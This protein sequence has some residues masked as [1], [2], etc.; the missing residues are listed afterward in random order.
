MSKEDTAVLLISH[1]STRP[2]GKVVFDEIKEKF[3]EKTGLKT[4]VG[5]M[6][7]SEPSVAGAVN[8][9]A[10]DENI[11]HIIGL[12]VFLA[13]GIHTRIDIPIMLELE[14]LEVD[15]R[16][17]DGNYP[18]DHYL[19]GL[20]DINFSGELDL[21]DAIGP[22]PRLLEIIKNRIE[23][24]LEESELDEDAKTGVMIVSHGSRLGYN[25]EF[26][27]DLF[28]QFEAQCDYPSSFGFM[29]L[30]T[31]DIPS[32]TNKLTE[33]NE[34]D[35][36]VVVPVFIAPGKHTTHDIPIILRLMEEEHHHHEHDHDHS[37][38]HEHSH[39]HDHEHSHG[40][41]HDHS[42]DLTPIDFEGEVLYPEPICADD[43]LIE[44]LESMI[45]DYL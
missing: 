32:A 6:K 1:G 44:I 5:Y 9:L 18:E 28:T 30:E 31:P 2:Y 24:A 34:I 40:H 38:D 4:E 29:E 14:P 25:K 27:T 36:L 41:H 22:N 42:H 7:V 21:L 3:I 13:P 23:T 35:R 45:Q 16:Q 15:P 33:E 26:L 20:D 11:K 43:V 39:G 12:P 19:C 10:E 17:P 8:I 37:H